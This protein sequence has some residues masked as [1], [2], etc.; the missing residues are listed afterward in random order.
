MAEK[1]S[2][3]IALEGGKAIE[4]QLDSIGQAGKQ[5]FEEIVQAA[6][7]AGGFKNL[8]PEEVTAKLR[9]MG[10]VGKE[11]FDKISGAVQGA[12]RMEKLVGIVQSVEK[13]FE[14]VSAAVASLARAL[15]GIGVIAGVAGAAIAKGMLDAAD[16]IQKADAEAIKLGTSLEKFDELK[17]GLEGFG[18]SAR[19]VASGLSEIGKAAEK[20]RLDQVAEDFKFLQE[21]AA[22][23]FGGQGTEQWLRLTEAMQG[24][25]RVADAARKAVTDLGGV[26]RGELPQSLGQLIIKFGDTREAVNAFANQLLAMPDDANRSSMALASLGQAGVGLV[27]A[28]RNGQITVDQF[29]QSL[30]TMTQESANAING[31]VQATNRLMTAWENLKTALAVKLIDT[32]AMETVARILDGIN[33]MLS[34]ATWE[35]WAEAAKAAFIMVFEPI[36][37]LEVKLAQIVANLGANIWEGFANAATA[38]IDSI[39][40]ALS[41]LLAKIKAVV[42]ALA[43]IARGGGT[44]GSVTPIPGNARGGLLG[45]R[46]TGTSDSNLAWV[47]RGEHIMPAR[48]VKQ[49]GVL[50]LLEAL[51]RSGGN[52]RG[53]MD[54]MGRFAGG[55][56]VPRLPAFAAGGMVGG[57][58]HYGT[59]D[60]RIDG[61]NVRVAAPQSAMEQLSRLAVT[62][63]MTS[64]GKK[65]GFIG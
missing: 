50:A 47:S 53:V 30:A 26:I 2:I 20:A 34:G 13:G 7:K 10:V 21:A 56:M 42:S 25:G 59:L 48:A 23:G 27:Q 43:G 54:G 32:G 60:L 45:G 37:A 58:S 36:G 62:R 24:G 33:R 29:K 11:A 55:G 52:L 51:R 49:P 39:M 19:D 3:T 28:L 22:R 46:G 4:Q 1:L 12:T 5:A 41:S 6:E 17:Q 16:A 61:A 15:P 18:L 8:R 44:P 9:E 57:M 31:V 63:R 14:G 65:P 64:T 38:A 35:Q 40:D